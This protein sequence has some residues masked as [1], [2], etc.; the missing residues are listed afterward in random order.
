MDFPQGYLS[1]PIS[2][3]ITLQI[4]L[5]LGM[6]FLLIWWAHQKIV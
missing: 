3:L 6:K 5:G 2:D 4:L 1:R